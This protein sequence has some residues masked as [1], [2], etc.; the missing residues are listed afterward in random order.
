VNRR[1]GT[2]TLAKT[3]RCGTLDEQDR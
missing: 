1:K 3:R 2:A